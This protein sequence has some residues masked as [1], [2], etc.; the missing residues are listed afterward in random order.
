MRATF[1]PWKGEKKG[2]KVSRFECFKD[3]LD[4]TLKTCDFRT[5]KPAFP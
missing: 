4:P 3:K 5:R 2:S 1:P